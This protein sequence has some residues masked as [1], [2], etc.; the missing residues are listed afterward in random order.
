MQH[1]Y[2]FV[3]TILKVELLIYINNSYTSLEALNNEEY[4]NP[5]FN[6]KTYAHI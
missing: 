5:V 3:N 6:C 4:N 1:K 2:K